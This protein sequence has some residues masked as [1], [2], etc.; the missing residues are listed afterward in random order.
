MKGGILI[1]SS[2]LNSNNGN[3][4]KTGQN[5][6]DGDFLDFGKNYEGDNDN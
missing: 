2:S 1:L 6:E 3:N 4:E 5:K